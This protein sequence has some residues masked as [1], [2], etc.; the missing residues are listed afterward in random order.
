MLLL[1][2]MVIRARGHLLAEEL[3]VGLVVRLVR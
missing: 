1:G 2:L 3:L